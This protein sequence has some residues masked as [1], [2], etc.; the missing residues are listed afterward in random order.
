M[1]QTPD[2]LSERLSLAYGLALREFFAHYEVE[3]LSCV[4]WRNRAPWSLPVRQCFDSFFLFPLTGN[5]RLMLGARRFIIKPHSY[6][7]LADGERHSLALEAG[8]VRLEQIALHCRIQ[9]RWQ[10]PLLARFSSP[11]VKLPDSARWYRVLAD[12]AAL[13]TTDREL[14]QHRGKVL[15]S[16]LMVERLREEKDLAPLHRDGDP[17]IEHVLQRMKEGLAAPELSIDAL[18]A[19]IG[20]TATQMRKLFRRETRQ[21][22]KQYLHRLRL[23]KAVHLLR[24]S[25]QSIK[26]VALESGFATDNYFHLVFRKQFGVTPAAFREREILC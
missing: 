6:L 11:L 19:E 7:A 2:P 20:L 12:L 4:Y 3:I 5:V 25:T 17:R 13:M 1:P 26:Q 8:H 15:V 9:D 14:G 21:G 22:P 18:A 16:E 23:E 24:Y 10:R